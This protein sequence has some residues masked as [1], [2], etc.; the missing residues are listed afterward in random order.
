MIGEI[1]YSCY[2]PCWGAN[3]IS[4]RVAELLAAR[5]HPFGTAGAQ[6]YVYTDSSLRF[7]EVVP[8]GRADDGMGFLVYQLKRTA[9]DERT[10]RPVP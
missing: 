3:I 10:A 2:S 6:N 9:S 7:D 4:G 5:T 8:S 1:C